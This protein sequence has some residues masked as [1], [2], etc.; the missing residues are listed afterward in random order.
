SKHHLPCSCFSFPCAPVSCR[1]ANEHPK[2]RGLD[3]GSNGR[4]AATAARRCGSSSA[5]IGAARVSLAGRQRGGRG[6]GRTGGPAAGG[7]G[8]GPS[9]G[10]RAAGGG[11]QR[12]LCG[13]RV[14]RHRHAT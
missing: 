5:A 2:R 14:G 6:R 13:R 7:G 1:H 3:N 8:G 10:G 11:N 9:A 4:S 12:R